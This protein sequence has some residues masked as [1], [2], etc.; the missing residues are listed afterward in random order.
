[1][2]YI[3]PLMEH[4]VEVLLYVVPFVSLGIAGAVKMYRNERLRKRARAEH[5]ALVTWAQA[6]GWRAYEGVDLKYAEIADRITGLSGQ[7]GDF[8]T[9]S[10]V[11]AGNDNFA[12][13]KK[14]EYGTILARSDAAGEMVVLGC[15]HEGETQHYLFGSLHTDGPFS[16]YTADCLRA[17]TVHEDGT[18][19]A[20]DDF[21]PARFFAE[22]EL[23]SRLR[24][25]DGRILLRTPG[26]LSEERIL[27][28]ASRLSTLHKSLPRRPDLGP[29]R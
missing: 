16:P 29:M 17:G 28:I 8:L 4:L 12:P 15:W 10:L 20:L 18:A 1:M 22:L 19:P 23:P 24:F 5:D 26:W 14:W 2:G 9:G 21:A 6:N 27:D 25:L 7:P 11:V 3:L 13:S